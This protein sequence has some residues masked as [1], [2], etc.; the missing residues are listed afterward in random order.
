MA[1]AKQYRPRGDDRTETLNIALPASLKTWIKAE[2]EAQGI[3]VSFFA[4]EVFQ[5]KRDA[6]KAGK[7][8]AA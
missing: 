1:E 2:A 4:T 3:T 8:K 7:G 5:E 6:T